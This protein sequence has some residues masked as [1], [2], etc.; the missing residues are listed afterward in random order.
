MLL[1][2]KACKRQ[3]FMRLLLQVHTIEDRNMAT[4]CLIAFLCLA[5]LISVNAEEVNVC[6]R[7]SGVVHHGKLSM[8]ELIF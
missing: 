8:G 3:S 1:I 5:V 6:A 2:Q 4:Q 7:D